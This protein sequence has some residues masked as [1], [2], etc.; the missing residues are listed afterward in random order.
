MTKILNVD[1]NPIDR[2]LA[3]R[4]QVQYAGSADPAPALI[5]PVVGSLKA[6]RFRICGSD[7]TG[8]VRITLA[9][10][11][12]VINAMHHGNLEL[13]SALREGDERQYHQLAAQRKGQSPYKD[14]HVH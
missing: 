6:S 5:P 9:L 1:D 12:A 2:Q 14:R 10:R 4:L 7:E 11:E 3:A 13:S 8:L